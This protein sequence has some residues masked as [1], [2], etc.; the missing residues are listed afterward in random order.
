MHNN[1]TSWKLSHST[2]QF[3]NGDAIYCVMETNMWLENGTIHI[4]VGSVLTFC[5]HKDMGF[6]TT[7]CNINALVLG[8]FKLGQP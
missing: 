3:K 5:K 2:Q 7:F 8:Q 4:I 6:C 1:F